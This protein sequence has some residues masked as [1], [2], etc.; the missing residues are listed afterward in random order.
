MA[1][2]L[3]FGLSF[4]HTGHPALLYGLYALSYLLGSWFMCFDL[5]EALKKKQ[6]DIDLLMLLAA[7]GAAV[8]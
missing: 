7:I 8:L 4:A 1:L 2:V 3:A 5:L 6:L